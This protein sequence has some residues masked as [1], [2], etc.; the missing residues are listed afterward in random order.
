MG[1]NWLAKYITSF[2]HAKA[3]KK[4]IFNLAEFND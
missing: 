1:L 2:T 4:L 3:T